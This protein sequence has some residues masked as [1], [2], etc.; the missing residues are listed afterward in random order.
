MRVVTAVTGMLAVFAFLVLRRSIGSAGAIAAALLFAVSPGAVYFSRCCIHEMLLICFTLWAVVLAAASSPRTGLRYL[1]GAA[2]AAGLAFATKE[3][4]I[5]TAGVIAI[6]A[7]SSR[8][9]LLAREP[10]PSTQ[11]GWPRSRAS[12]VPQPRRSVRAC[13]AGD[14]ACGWSPRCSCSSR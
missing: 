10:G 6:A 11:G 4:A 12:P 3:T 9:L 14:R 2:A 7:G 8:T 1:C 5:I 13:L